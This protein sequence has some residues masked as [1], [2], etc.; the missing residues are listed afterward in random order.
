MSAVKISP[1]G[2]AGVHWFVSRFNAAL[3]CMPATPSCM[4]LIPTGFS[5]TTARAFKRDS[6]SDTR[7]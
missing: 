1:H 4:A 7:A 5:A 3:S 2:V 6:S